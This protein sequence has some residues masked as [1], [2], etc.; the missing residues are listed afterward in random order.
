M[1]KKFVMTVISVLIITVVAIAF[2]SC[3]SAQPPVKEGQ[4]GYGRT[5]GNVYDIDS[6]P[7]GV[8]RIG[9]KIEDTS[10][11]GK[12][13]ISANCRD[14][15][16]LDVNNGRYT[17]TYLCKQGMLSQVSV[18]ID[19]A[20]REVK[21]GDTKDGYT[22]YSFEV[23]KEELGSKMQMTCIVDIMKKQVSYSV[24]PDIHSAK[25]VG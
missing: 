15:I 1:K 5:L 7:T 14:Y 21:Q 12:T 4:D 18:K 20:E 19:G 25:L 11:M 22:P 6:A 10:V 3:N 17:V 23:S 2:A 13:M 8:F 24:I 16:E 9:Y